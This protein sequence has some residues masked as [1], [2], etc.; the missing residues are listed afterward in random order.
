MQYKLY[1]IFYTFFRVA[2]LG[3]CRLLRWE[4]IEE[5]KEVRKKKFQEKTTTVKKENKIQERKENTLSTKKVKKSKNFLF[6]FA[7]FWLRAYF[8]DCYLFSC[9]RACF[10]LIFLNS[11]FFRNTSCV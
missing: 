4:F 9:T 8:L 2:V 6:F 5:K 11:T 3:I 10:F 7:V 1:H